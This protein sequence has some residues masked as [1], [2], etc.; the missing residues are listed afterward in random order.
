VL[1]IRATLNKA[2]VHYVGWL[3]LNKFYRIA[4]QYK[5]SAQK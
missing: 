1:R 4:P 2:P 3:R 5:K